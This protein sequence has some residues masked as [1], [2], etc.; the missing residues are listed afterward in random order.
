MDALALDQFLVFATVADTGSFARAARRLGRAQSAVTYAIGRLEAE[1]GAP[2][3]DRSAYRP[4]LNATGRALLPRAQRILAEVDAFR[5]QARGVA[6][7]LEA[8]LSIV[9][10]ALA[11]M[12]GLAPGLADFHARFPNVSLR[13]STAPMT[14]ALAALS[15]GRA[16]VGVVHL[17]DQGLDGMDWAFA[18]E[19]P[20]VAVAAP[21]HALSALPPPLT[22]SA[23]RDH[24]QLV[25]TDPDAQDAPDRGVVAVNTWRVADL[26]AKHALLLAGLGWG[27]MPRP[28]VDDDL[29]AGRLR[30]LTPERWDGGEVMPVLHFAVAHSAAQPPG[31]AGR[32]LFDRL[33][34]Q[35]RSAGGTARADTDRSPDAPPRAE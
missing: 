30:Q 1:V 19:A 13:L 20:L 3:F 32:W 17:L 9:V 23:L 8:R 18:L 27:S 35:P 5:I 33:R 2:L 26:A 7:G 6:Q 28:M 34:A 12:T 22:P 31:P 11:P 29:R 21:R 10:S 25:L 14:G 15:A 24:L 16:D 4:T